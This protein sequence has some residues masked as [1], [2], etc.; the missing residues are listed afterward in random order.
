MHAAR[1]TR[2]WIAGI[3]FS[4]GS[5]FFGR[6]SLVGGTLVLTDEAVLFRPLV[7]LGRA[8]E[9]PLSDIDDVSGYLDGSPRLQILARGCK[10][11]VLGVVPTRTTTFWSSD[12]SARDDA[13]AAIS[14]ARS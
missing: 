9:I 8:K 13:V 11:L 3:P 1:S 10:P 2:E 7:G 14:A 12:T 6:L 5:S 4:R